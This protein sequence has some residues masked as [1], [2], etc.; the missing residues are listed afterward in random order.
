MKCSLLLKNS[1]Y[2]PLS[3]EIALIGLVFDEKLLSVNNFLKV[4]QL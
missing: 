2:F 3:D 4:L 1:I